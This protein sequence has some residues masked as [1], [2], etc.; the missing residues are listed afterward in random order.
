MDWTPERDNRLR[1][2]T[3]AYETYAHSHVGLG[4][5]WGQV[6]AE[7]VSDGRKSGRTANATT[8]AN[9]LGIKA[10]RGRL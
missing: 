7:I 8:A 6:V 5:G 4:D 3:D 2:A 1:A 10:E 9:K